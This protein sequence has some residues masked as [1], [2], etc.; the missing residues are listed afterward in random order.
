MHKYTAIIGA[1]ALAWSTLSTAQVATIDVNSLPQL[2]QM[3]QSVLQL[4]NQLDQQLKQYEAMTGTSG[5]G[6]M[7]GNSAYDAAQKF[8]DSWDD[9]YG[10]S[11]PYKSKAEGVLDSLD[12]QTDGMDKTEAMK[13]TRQR[14]RVNNAQ[15]RVVMQKV[16]DDQKAEMRTLE[17]LQKE[18]KQAQTQKQIEDLQARV[19]ISQGTINAQQMRMQ[20]MASLQDAQQRMYT[21][22]QR[23]AF[24]RKMV[25]DDVTSEPTSPSI[26]E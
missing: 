9:V 24:M 21:D 1:A 8:P 22:Q 11:N 12:Q 23:R 18:I 20:N 17:K 25:G 5:F 10:G 13:Y 19:N 4:K 14:V 15:D 2:I 16:Y 3:Q 7:G 6:G 26:T